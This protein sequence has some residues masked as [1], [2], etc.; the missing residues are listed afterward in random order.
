MPVE[1]TGPVC[2]TYALSRESA[3]L[4]YR[5]MKILCVTPWPPSP[6]RTGA[7]ARMHGLT[8]KLALRHDVTVIS[9]IEDPFDRETAARSLGTYCRRFSL[10]R[11]S[12]GR[13]GWAKRVHQ[14]RSLFSARSFQRL[15]FAIPA[16]Q[17]E[18][19]RIL[20]EEHYDAVKLDF[21]YLAYLDVTGSPKGTSRPQV[22]I[23]TH[24]IAYHLLRQVAR[25]RVALSRRVFAAI[26]W[27]KLAREERA[28]YREADGILVCSDADRRRVLDDVPSARVAVIPNA[29][30][31][32]FYQSRPHDP[33]P[34][35]RTILFFGNLS[36][37]PNIDG[38]RFFLDDVW[39]RI[40]GA[41]PAAR[42]KIVGGSAPAWLSAHAGPR[43][44]VTGLV[45]DLRPHLASASAI[46]V[47]LRLGS[48][49]RLKI[50]EAMAMGKAIVSTT[51]GAEGIDAIAGQDLLIADEPSEF[52]ARVVDLLDDPE[53]AAALGR[54]GR[55]LAEERYSWV[56]AAM[57][58]ERF[59]DELISATSKAVSQESHSL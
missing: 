22:V 38:M 16:L 20:Q 50:V 42:F 5:R 25:S 19:S 3:R 29:A 36:T 58:L 2:Y 23:D 57:T 10:V 56:G 27:R 53:R 11:G 51:L 54:R 46:V 43:V 33:S 8:A 34:D 21:T 4:S 15:R 31:V 13:P 59:L 12:D 52:A 44:E 47:P 41:R 7:Q 55:S 35:G 9:L 26:N 30:D 40:A 18:V 14:G 28:A 1:T 6:P 45:E 37:F 17:D 49:T 32:D 39:P 48:G 24:D